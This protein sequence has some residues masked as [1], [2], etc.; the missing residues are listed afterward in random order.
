MLTTLRERWKTAT[1]LFDDS[2]KTAFLQRRLTGT[3]SEDFF[4]I[5]DERAFRANGITST[6]HLFGAFLAIIDD[7]D[8][9]KNTA[10]CDQFYAELKKLGAAPSYKSAI[11]YQ[12]QAKLAVGI[13]THGPEALLSPLPTLPE[14]PRD[15][16]AEDDF[17]ALPQ[18]ETPP[19]VTRTASRREEV[20]PRA[21]DYPEEPEAGT[22][23]TPSG[24]GRSLA[25]LGLAG[26]ILF[27]LASYGLMA[28]SD[29]SGALTVWS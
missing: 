11:I 24:G 10:K 2:K 3:L 12:L 5:K 14:V 23:R 6:D 16:L 15:A 22:E 13:D 8:P 21:L 28:P 18:V 29:H 19:P 25:C 17:D 27:A 4:G 20:T 26:A 1:S 7:P 9:S